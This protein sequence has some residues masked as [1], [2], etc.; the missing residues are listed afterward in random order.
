MQINSVERSGLQCPAQE[1]Q[2][3][4]GRQSSD[5]QMT[6]IPPE[7]KLP[8]GDVTAVVVCRFGVGFTSFQCNNESKSEN[9]ELRLN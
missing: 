8:H 2:M 1:Q 4:W 7:L 3:D 9:G 5:W 6:T